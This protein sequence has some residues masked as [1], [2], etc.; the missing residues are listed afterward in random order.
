MSNFKDRYFG[1]EYYGVLQYLSIPTTVDPFNIDS[2]SKLSVELRTSQDGLKKRWNYSQ[3]SNNPIESITFD[4]TEK[5]CGILKMVFSELST[6]IEASE[7]IKVY[8]RD[9]LV[10]DG[11][12]DNDVDMSNPV[13]TASPFWKRFEEV[14]YSHTFSGSDTPEDILSTVIAAVESSTGVSWNAVK[15]DFGAY[16]PVVA[17]TYASVTVKDIID[18]MVSMSGST[19]YWGVDT[20]RDFFV[21]TYDN[22]KALSFSFYAKDN[23]DFEKVSITEDY[24]KINMTEAVV[25]KKVSGGGEGAHVGQVGRSDT[26]S[27]PPLSIADKIRQKVG[28]YTA[29]EYV[30]DTTALVW[31][32]EELKKQADRALTVKISGINTDVVIPLPGDRVLAE[33]DFKKAMEIAVD[34]TTATG[35][36][37]ATPDSTGKGKDGGTSIKLFNTAADSSYDFGRDVGWYKQKKIGF[38]I[39]APSG[40]VIEVKFTGTTKISTFKFEVLDNNLLSYYD[41]DVT[42]KFRYITFTYVTGNIYVDDIQVFCETKRQETVIIKKTT[43][44]ITDAGINCDVE[45][46]D[47]INYESHVLAELNRKIKILEAINNI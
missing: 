33:D 16:T 10:Y 41:F 2:K 1:I 6:P 27:Y 18:S 14:V 9:V 32:Y 15:V 31:A 40:T 44:K 47:V 29:S 13:V 24:S 39:I 12:V 4:L 37:N 21:K 46:G 17:V 5:G 3:E 11:I 30:T 23:A 20:N 28:K 34:C 35:W 45:G 42:H 8:M 22:T 36:T 19:L 25:Y 26:P 43:I 7:I 38:Y